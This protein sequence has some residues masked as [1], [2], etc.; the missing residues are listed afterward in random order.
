MIYVWPVMVE[1]N[2]LVQPGLF[3]LIGDVIIHFVY[4]S[5]YFIYLISC[6]HV[7][8]HIWLYALG[9]NSLPASSGV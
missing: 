4:Y 7:K 6:L 9:V 1:Y 3:R 8:N 5:I 2:F